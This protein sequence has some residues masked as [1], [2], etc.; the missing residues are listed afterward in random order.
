MNRKT[1]VS[2]KN[3]R[4][5]LLPYGCYF[6]SSAALFTHYIRNGPVIFRC[7]ALQLPGQST[8]KPFTFDEMLERGRTCANSPFNLTRKHMRSIRNARI[9]SVD[10]K[11]MD[12][13]DS[14]I[15]SYIPGTFSGA[16]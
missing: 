4:F 8:K 7:L 14:G 1:W 2:I 10:S 6:G 3:A 15:S 12:V 5:I 11:R 16:V 9:V 13:G